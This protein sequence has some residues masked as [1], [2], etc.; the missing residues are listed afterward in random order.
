MTDNTEEDGSLVQQIP[1]RRIANVAGLVLLLIVV[2]PFLVYAVPQVVGAEQSYVVLSASME[3]TMSPGDAILI[4][5]TPAAEIQQGD[6]ITFASGGSGQPTTHRVIEVV[7]R[8]G[9]T[10]FMTQGDN[11]EDPDQSLVTPAELEGRVL[12]V[13]GYPVIIPLIGHV[14][15]FASTTQGLITLLIVPLALLVVSE[16]WDIVAGASGG[17]SAGAAATGD[18]DE[19]EDIETAN[20]ETVSTERDGGEPTSA[21]SSADGDAPAAEGLVGSFTE[22]VGGIKEPPEAPTPEAEPGSP[23]TEED[24]DGATVESSGADMS[25]TDVGD[26]GAEAEAI[27][28]DVGDT[29]ETD[30]SD[31]GAETEATETDDTE[32]GL[33]FSAAELQLGLAVL[34]I[35][36]AYGLWVAYATFFQVWAFAVTASVAAGL[37]LLGGLYVVGGQEDATEA[38]Q[39]GEQGHEP[40]V[41]EQ[42]GGEGSSGTNGSES[43]PVSRERQEPPMAAEPSGASDTGEPGADVDEFIWIGEADDA[44]RHQTGFDPNSADGE[45]NGDQ[46]RADTAKTSEASNND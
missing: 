31:A 26:T 23:D 34:G 25:E 8:N 22:L 29:A 45:M 38:V 33:V 44:G 6:I 16:I 4:D 32:A 1:W 46:R 21:E 43:V 11:V 14:I 12:S 3:P 20:S 28:T 15:F 19:A 9:E 42:T 41:R 40:R 18:G 39:A 17:T 5:D 10:A 2:V 36:F 37:L 7:E 24:G 35:F 27:E 30:S 13:G